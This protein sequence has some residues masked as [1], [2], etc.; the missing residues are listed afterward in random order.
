MSPGTRD[1]GLTSGRRLAPGKWATLRGDGAGCGRRSGHRCPRPRDQCAMARARASAAP[2]RTMVW[3]PIIPTTHLMRSAFVDSIFASSR[4][5][6]SRRSLSGGEIGLH[7]FGDGGRHAFGLLGAELRLV[8]QAP[9]EAEG[10]ECGAHSLYLLTR[11]VAVM[12]VRQ[13]LSLYRGGHEGVVTVGV[14]DMPIDPVA[15]RICV[16]LRAIARSGGRQLLTPPGTHPLKRG[17]FRQA[18]G[19]FAS[20]R[21][22][23]DPQEPKRCRPHLRP[24]LDRSRDPGHRKKHERGAE[25][26]RSSA[27]GALEIR[28]G[29]ERASLCT[30]FGAGVIAV[31]GRP[32][33]T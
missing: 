24:S 5:S 27:F 20:G 30:R 19:T 23:L 2:S 3:K 6:T 31:P 33:R 15:M 7:G 28:K 17:N 16:W 21:R 8:A 9:C 14:G 18:V 11:V 10:V 32:D 4:N 12:S 22:V 29:H 26:S 25:A 13:N 1:E